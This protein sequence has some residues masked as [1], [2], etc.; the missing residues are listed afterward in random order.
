MTLEI[1]LNE[2]Y[3]KSDKIEHGRLIKKFF[4]SLTENVFN[5]SWDFYQEYQKITKQNL[6]PLLESERNQYSLFASAINKITP[7]HLSECSFNK[8]EIEIDNS[9]RVDFWCLNK[10]GE[11]GKS[12]NY[13]IELKK[14]F[15]CLSKGTKSQFVGVLE[16][17]IN[18]L[19]TQVHGLK[20][21]KPGWHGDDDVY[22]GIVVIHGYHA[23]AKESEFNEEQIIYNTHKLL[24]GRL[25]AQLLMNT[26]TLPE[27]LGVQWDS[28]KC[29]F[30]SIV[31][32][33]ISTKRQ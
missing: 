27:E 33:A 16:K 20:K 29:K 24:D 10:N 18:E 25:G 14:G 30:I 19:V 26:W 32:I 8:S 7:I 2:E 3:F 6:L 12:I 31:G 11:D 1:S 23:A 5:Q 17:N 22:L 21:I 28:D 13:F 9:R 4:C 15:Y